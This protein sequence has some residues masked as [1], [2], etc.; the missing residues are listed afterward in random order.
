MDLNSIG[1]TKIQQ[2]IRAVSFPAGKEDVVSEAESNGAPQSV[3]SPSE[4]N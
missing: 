3:V 2:Y 4:E 1:M